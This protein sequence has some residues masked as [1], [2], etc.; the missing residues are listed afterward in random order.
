MV[1]NEITDTDLDNPDTSAEEE[2]VTFLYKLTSG[3]CPKSYGFNAARLAGLPASI[4]RR[5]FAFAKKLE[6]DMEHRRLCR[7]LCRLAS[8]ENASVPEDLWLSLNRVISL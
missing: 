8:D 6:R 7:S 1:E 2:S 4:A 3:A 5:G